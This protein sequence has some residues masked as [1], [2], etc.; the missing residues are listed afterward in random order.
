MRGKSMVSHH[1]V[2]AHVGLHITPL[3]SNNESTSHHYYEKLNRYVSNNG[4][5][6]S[7][8]DLIGSS[9]DPS[10]NLTITHNKN[11]SWETFPKRFH[12]WISSELK[13][14]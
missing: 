8:T 5:I 13:Y 2:K 11:R 9:T 7:S 10:L 12:K 3:S 1:R 6:K 4:E 14:I